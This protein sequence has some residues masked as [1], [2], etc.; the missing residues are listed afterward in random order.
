MPHLRRDGDVHVLDLGQEGVADTENRFHPDWLV[1]VGELLDEVEA[2]EGPAAL[3]TTGTGKFYS[4]GLDLEWLM[5]HGEQL[6]EYV[7]SVHALLRRVLLLP[8]P[9]VAACN[10]HVFAAGAMLATAHDAQ[11]MR[12]DRG[13]WCLPE[14]DI[15]IPFTEGMN[16]LLTARLPKRG[17]HEAM[18]TGRRFGGP[19]ALAAG[20]VTA[21]ADEAD[22]LPTAVAQAQALAAKRGDTLGM[23]KSRMY[24]DAARTLAE[25][26]GGL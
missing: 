5:G 12:A 22:V 17:A 15:H 14:V 11:V 25:D 19:D 13:Y 16:A 24:A 21:T 23:I 6:A 3:V 7:T 8:M 20:L 10:G 26:T 9:T 18:T 1:A 4:N 2:T